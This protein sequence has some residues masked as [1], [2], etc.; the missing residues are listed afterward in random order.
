MTTNSGNHI[1]KNWVIGILTTI[2]LI[3]FGIGIKGQIQTSRDHSTTLIEH[4]EKITALESQY[5]YIKERLDEIA[6]AVKD[7]K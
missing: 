2:C 5:E 6:Q 4:G 7:E 3:L 1:T